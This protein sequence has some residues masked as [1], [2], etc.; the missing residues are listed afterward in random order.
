MSINAEEKLKLSHCLIG[1]LTVKTYGGVDVQLRVILTLH[2]DD[3]NGQAQALTHS[4]TVLYC[5]LDM[6]LGGP[7]S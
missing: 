4:E 1:H 3:V 7:Q 2:L 6:R 5:P